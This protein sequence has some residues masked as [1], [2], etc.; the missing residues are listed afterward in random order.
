MARST[1][2]RASEPTTIA[3]LSVRLR[4]S[5][6]DLLKLNPDLSKA[7]VIPAQTLVRYYA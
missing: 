4:S 1:N 5:P 6:T 3:P 7:L 2:P